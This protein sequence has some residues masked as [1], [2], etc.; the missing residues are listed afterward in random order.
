M[1]IYNNININFLNEKKFLM[2]GIFI[3]VKFFWFI[4]CL[5]FFSP[6]ISVEKLKNLVP[7]GV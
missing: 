2:L 5:N 6:E 7:S 4:F 1:C 3:L